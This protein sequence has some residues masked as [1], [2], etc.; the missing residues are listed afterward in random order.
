MIRWA[1]RL[2]FEKLKQVVINDEQDN[3]PK[4]H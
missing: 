1:I 4:E 2:H 3:N